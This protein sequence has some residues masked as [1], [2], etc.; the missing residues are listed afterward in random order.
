VDSG[1]I[2]LDI[3]LTRIRDHRSKAYFLDAVKAYKAGALRGALTSAWVAVA[4]DLIAKHRELSGMGDAAA[5]AY[6]QEWDNATTH[7]NVPRLLAL[8]AS[9][10]E[11]ATTNSQVLNHT[12]K[13][14]LQRLRDDRH[15]CAHPAFS[16]AA[17]LFEPTHELVRLHLVSAVNLVLT[18]EP[19]QG[20]QIFDIFDVDVQTPGFPGVH[21][22][23]LDYVEHRYLARVRPQSLINFGIVLAKSRLKGVPSQWEP[24]RHKIT[25][26]L[27][28][29]R[30]RASHAWPDVAQAIVQQIDT[31]QPDHRPR[32]IAFI[33]E[34]PNFWPAIQETTRTALQ[35]TIA[36]T[37]AANLTNFDLVSGLAIPDLRESVLALIPG[38]S[39]QQITNAISVYPIA[40]LWP[41]A[42]LGYRES[43]S[44]RG[45]EANFE[46]LVKP[47]IGR[48]SPQQFDELLAAIS[49]NSQN[50]D[51]G[52]TDTLLLD[53]LRGSLP[54]QY[55]TVGARNTFCQFL[56]GRHRFDTYQE[57]FNLLQVDGWRV[58]P[59]EP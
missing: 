36:N 12:A 53:M 22:R 39:L 51:A 58:P 24:V 11:D 6:I 43:G 30:D 20:R 1:F 35:Q 16:D 28:A 49:G 25:W 56:R 45:S 34:F 14:H 52:G 17:E 41:G 31:L 55:P 33:A 54:T 9:I 13:T 26:S 15:L 38:L 10:L 3:L 47:F 19:L 27:A 7:N 40:E 32:A 59:A 46:S 5:T 57:V 8:E 37:S 29:I 48:I 4:Y 18:Q 44:F 21:D 2:D 23:I 50:W 42:L